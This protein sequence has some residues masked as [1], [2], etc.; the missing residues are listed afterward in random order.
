MTTK[1]L[2]RFFA[3][4]EFAFSAHA[5]NAPAWK[6]EPS[7]VPRALVVE[8]LWSDFFRIEPA[9][10]S[11]GLLSQHAYISRSP[12]FGGYSRL[13]NLPKDAELNRFS[14][15]VIANL[16]A[17]TL[18]AE[19]LGAVREFVAQGGGLVVLG[20]YWAYSRGAYDGTALAEMLPVTFPPENRIPPNRDGLP[21]HPAPQATW[22]M[23]FD[24]AAKPGA[25]Y[26]QALVPKA[27]AT[28]QLLAGEKPAMISGT[29]GKGRV[30][31]CALTANGDPPQGVLPFWDW[32]DFPKLLGH[33]VDWAAG[34]RPLAADVASATTKPVLSEDEMN[35]LALGSGVTPEMARRI[36]ERP[37][38]Q[39]A[40]ALLS[41]VMRPEGGGKVDLASAYRALLPFAKAEWGVMLRGS[42]EKF[43]P[44]IKGRQAGLILLGASKD[45]AAY[46]IIHDAVQR[47]TAKDAA[48]E[49]F[50]WLGNSDA[51]PLL[52]EL[53]ARAESACNAMATDDEPAPDVFAHK[54]GSTI[55][56]AAISLHRLGDPEAVPRLL[57][58]YRRVRLYDRIFHNATKRR[59]YETDVQGVGILRR[60]HEGA[61]KLAAALARLREQAG[62][63]PESQ[64]AAFIRSAMEATDPAEVEWLCLA[65]EQSASSVPAAAWQPLTKARDGIIARM[66][67]ALVNGH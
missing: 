21:L 27:G 36:C 23:A 16:D 52:R 11:A 10:H 51:I 65:L 60:L 38:R 7:L 29:F 2:L 6:W 14:V 26:V 19:R 63:V 28:V 30:V 45:P 57:Q 35:S 31:A 24:F 66:A 56:E 4:F 47:E 37:D 1:S 43:S 59:V 64:R 44:D 62:P 48:I 13:Y 61:E 25:F 33:A 5:A 22:K 12:Y 3:L 8:G 40:D 15:I 46:A 41:H 67:A 20:G 32:P 54:Q 18:N 9:M 17:P 50:G 55:V 39:T 42:L 58:V 34:A 53:L 49:A